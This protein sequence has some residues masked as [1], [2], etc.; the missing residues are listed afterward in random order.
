MIKTT[1]DRIGMGNSQ[2][3]ELVCTYD[4]EAKV[5]CDCNSNT[6]Q[7]TRAGNDTNTPGCEPY[8]ITSLTT[9]CSPTDRLSS[10]CGPLPSDLFD[11]TPEERAVL[12]P[13][14]VIWGNQSPYFNFP[15][16]R[17]NEYVVKPGFVITGVRFMQSAKGSVDRL[18]GLYIRPCQ[19][20]DLS[21]PEEFIKLTAFGGTGGHSIFEEKATAGYAL[22]AILVY[23]GWFVA[24]AQCRWRNFQNPSQYQMGVQ[25][26]DKYVAE[27]LNGSSFPCAQD[28]RARSDLGKAS[29]RYVIPPS[30]YMYDTL[31]PG[32]M[33]P[34]APLMFQADITNTRF[35]DT[36][37]PTLFATAVRVYTNAYYSGV[38]AS[39][40]LGYRD[41]A[42][43][44]R[45]LSEPRLQRL[46]CQSKGDPYMCGAQYFSSTPSCDTIMSTACNS[47]TRENALAAPACHCLTSRIKA[48]VCYDKKCLEPTAYRPAVMLRVFSP[49]PDLLEC[50]QYL[51]LPDEIKDSVVN[52]VALQQTCT[53]TDGS[54]G[55]GALPL[56]EP[57]PNN[58]EPGTDTTTLG[59]V[60][61]DKNKVLAAAA[62]SVVGLLVT[63]GFALS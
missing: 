41:F 6:L 28:G 62:V 61:P 46:C 27:C 18:E 45:V 52:N 39:I 1:H 26:K 37:N 59:N 55:D 49:C 35:T 34:D 30:E 29:P 48:P 3:S 23:S 25:M 16:M 9:A 33:G 58:P 7:E 57:D 13:G 60:N 47:L 19:P 24:G 43:V 10:T 32:R 20:I 31:A 8:Q 38:I 42:G 11:G 44:L 4:T 63:T 50:N 17:V 21:G 14:P 15:V 5:N 51:G 2:P 56:D 53:K 36:I 54:G 12:Q 40:Q 22:S